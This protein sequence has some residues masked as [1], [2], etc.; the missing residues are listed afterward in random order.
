MSFGEADTELGLIKTL[1]WLNL[2]LEAHLLKK[3]LY[4]PMAIKT[5]TSNAIS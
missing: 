4:E 3:V 2:I 1:S 5:L